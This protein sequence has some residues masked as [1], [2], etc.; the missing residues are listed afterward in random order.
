MEIIQQGT[1]TS[2]ILD[3]MDK[4]PRKYILL[5]WF[6]PWADEKVDAVAH[7]S[8]CLAN[9]YALLTE[10]QARNCPVQRR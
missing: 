4:L 2:S 7:G 3:A 1:E 5:L 8:Q 9:K 6:L 10:Y